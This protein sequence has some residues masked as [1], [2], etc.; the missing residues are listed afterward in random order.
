MWVYKCTWR[1]WVDFCVR[2]CAARVSVIFFEQR[3]VHSS[4][5]TLRFVSAPLRLSLRFHI[6][7]WSVDG[8]A[9]M[10]EQVGWHRGTGTEVRFVLAECLRVGGGGGGA[11]ALCTDPWW[12]GWHRDSS[13]RIIVAAA[14]DRIPKYCGIY[15][16]KIFCHHGWPHWLLCGHFCWL[17]YFTFSIFLLGLLHHSFVVCRVAKVELCNDCDYVSVV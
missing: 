9:R 1:V 4:A 17:L 10:D 3:N 6:F 2:L 16:Y 14:A 11:T 8:L 15:I 5:C 7:V 12:R 13:S